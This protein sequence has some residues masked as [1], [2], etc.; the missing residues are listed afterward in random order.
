MHSDRNIAERQFDS[1][2]KKDA[3][4]GESDVDNNYYKFPI[5]IK[6]LLIDVA[7]V[8]MRLKI[9][10]AIEEIK[11]EDFKLFCEK[12]GGLDAYK[13]IA[14]YELI[15]DPVERIISISRKDGKE[16][17]EI[18][19]KKI[20]K[21][22]GYNINILLSKKDECSF[23]AAININGYSVPGWKKV[24]SF[25]RKFDIR[26]AVFLGKRFAP[27]RSRLHLRFYKGDKNWYAIAHIDFNWINWDLIQIHK[28]H[29]NSGKGDY[30]TG[31]KCFIECLRRY[32]EKNES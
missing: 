24:V 31:N 17:T 18:D 16:L 14:S 8:S 32:F 13:K 27:G 10:A 25:V 3:L 2:L 6:Q 22:L 9:D 23:D 12:N 1:V 7:P 4:A 29:N 20:L 30:K 15:N 28:S 11:P 26:I 5:F 21:D 19:V